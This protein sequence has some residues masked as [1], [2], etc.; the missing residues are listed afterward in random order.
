MRR[1]EFFTLVGGASL[2]LAPRAVTNASR[3]QS[4]RQQARGF[5]LPAPGAPHY[6]EI[7]RL[8]PKH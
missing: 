4:A 1:R 8:R 5:V 2:S 3:E 7:K 6:E